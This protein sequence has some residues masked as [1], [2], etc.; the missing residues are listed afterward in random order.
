MT[1]FLTVTVGMAHQQKA[2]DSRQAKYKSEVSIRN[3]KKGTN[4]E[5]PLHTGVSEADTGRL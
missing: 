5:L 4:G 1:D 2:G 3:K